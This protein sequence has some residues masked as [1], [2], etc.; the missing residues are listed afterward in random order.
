MVSSS[1][2][3]VKIPQTLLKVK[4]F[5]VQYCDRR[6]NSANHSDYDAVL[7]SFEV[8]VPNLSF[9]HFGVCQSRGVLVGELL[10]PA[11]YVCFETFSQG[12]A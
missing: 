2:F 10:L 7:E 1:I 12:K 4:E 8:C 5:L 3:Y 6:G 9:V 11:G